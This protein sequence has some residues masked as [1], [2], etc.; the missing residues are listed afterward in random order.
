MENLQP[1][2]SSQFWQLIDESNTKKN[3]QWHEYNIDEHLE[4]L[5]ELVAK[6]PDEQIVNFEID[7][8]KAI[9][10][11]DMAQIAE[12]NMILENEF[13]LKDGNY[14]VDEYLSDDGFIYFRCWLILKGKAFFDEIRQDI[15]NFV[16]GKYSFNIGDIWA[17]GLL[18]VA[19]NAYLVNHKEETSYSPVR[20]IVHPILK[21]TPE[22]DYDFGGNAMAGELHNGDE[23][24]ALYPKLIDSIAKIK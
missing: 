19:D 12:L 17:E 11:L 6:L 10:A 20:N 3:A 1:E 2:I 15:Q 24:Y 8:R 16:N 13:T 23:L 4:K 9:L 21:Q 18:Y 5:T 7:L 22:L 14:I